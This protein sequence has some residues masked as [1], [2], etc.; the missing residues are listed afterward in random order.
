MVASIGLFVGNVRAGHHIHSAVLRNII[1]SPMSF[2]EMTPVG[3]ILNRF[4][5]DLDVI[6]TLIAINFQ[7]WMTC[8]LRVLTVPVIIGYSTPLFIAVIIPLGILYFV[9]QVSFKYQKTVLLI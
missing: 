1:A 8:M 9:I 7:A 2:F 6:D 4:G 3:R 5:K